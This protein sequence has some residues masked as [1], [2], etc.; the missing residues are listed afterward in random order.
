MVLLLLL[1]W[2]AAALSLAHPRR[3]VPLQQAGLAIRLQ[4]VL[5][6][7]VTVKGVLRI[8]YSV[9]W[10]CLVDAHSEQGPHVRL[11]GAAGRAVLLPALS[12]QL[13]WRC[14]VPQL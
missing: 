4:A 9:D 10:E 11:C 2:A 14:H 8:V 12:D 5:L 13:R 6:A 3:L 7:D 1:L